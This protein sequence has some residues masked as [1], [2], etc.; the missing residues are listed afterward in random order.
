MT[1]TLE[2]TYDMAKALGTRAL[3]VEGARTVAEALRAARERFAGREGDFERMAGVAAIAVNGVLVAHRREGV[4]LADGDLVTFV[5]TAA[6][7]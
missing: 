6:G 2:L 5:K 4:R 1:V 7:G 3:Q